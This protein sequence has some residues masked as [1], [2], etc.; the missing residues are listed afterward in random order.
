[1]HVRFVVVQNPQFIPF[2]EPGD[3]DRMGLFVLL[4]LAGQGRAQIKPLLKTAL[5]LRRQFPSAPK[6]RRHDRRV[7]LRVI[8]PR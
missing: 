3:G 5:L 2:D 8:G 6:L 1:M 7:D 4:P